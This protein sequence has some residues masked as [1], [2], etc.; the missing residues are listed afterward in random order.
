MLPDAGFAH[1]LGGALLLDGDVV[2]DARHLVPVDGYLPVAP[3]PPG[4]DAARLREFAA[5][6]AAMVARWRGLVAAVQKYL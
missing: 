5:T 1:S 2:S 6:D 4:P 3:M